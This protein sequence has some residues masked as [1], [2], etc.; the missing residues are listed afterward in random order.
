MYGTPPI[1]EEEFPMYATSASD[2]IDAITEYRIINAG[3]LTAFPQLVQDL[4]PKA[5]GAQVLYFIQNGIETVLTG[6]TGAG[7]TVGKVHVDGGNASGMTQAQLMVSPLA[8][9]YLEQTGLM[10]RRVPCLELYHSSYLGI[11]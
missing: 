1:A 7:F 5:A 2:V 10:G 4:V 8:K 6:Q 3:G 9:M 11:W